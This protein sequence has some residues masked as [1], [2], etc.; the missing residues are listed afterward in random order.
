[1]VRLPSRRSGIRARH[2]QALLDSHGDHTCGWTISAQQGHVAWRCWFRWGCGASSGTSPVVESSR[3]CVHRRPPARNAPRTLASQ[4]Q[5]TGESH[6]SAPP[7]QSIRSRQASV[8]EHSTRSEG[9][10]SSRSGVTPHRSQACTRI[11]SLAPPTPTHNRP[12]P[13]SAAPVTSRCTRY[14]AMHPNRRGVMPTD[15][16]HRLPQQAQLRKN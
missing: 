2:C 7:S 14:V 4:Q 16:V 13:R 12:R 9:G 5:D 6:S 1:M 11:F 10:E 15:R 8:R 3:V